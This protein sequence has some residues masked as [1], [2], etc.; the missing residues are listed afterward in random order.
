[1][2][3]PFDP[4]P[5]SGSDPDS[6]T[7]T[8]EQDPHEK[9]EKK[10]LIRAEEIEILGLQEAKR[11]VHELQ[12]HQSKLERENEELRR[13]KTSEVMAEAL[14]RSEVHLRE[15]NSQLQQHCNKLMRRF[16]KCRQIEN[17]LKR[18]N[19]E[20]AAANRQLEIEKRLLSAVMEALPI[21]VAITN[22]SGGIVLQNKALDMMWGERQPEAQ[23]VDEYHLYKAFWADTGEPVAPEEWAAA[24]AVRQGKATLG[25]MLRLRRKDGAEMFVLNSSSPIHDDAGKIVGA[26][27][28][29][30]DVT[31]LKRVQNA[32]F[33]SE[34]HLR[35]FIEHSPVAIAVFDRDMHYLCAS[36]R[37]AQ[38]CAMELS[39]LIGR[40]AYEIH[41]VPE[42][43]KEANRR[44]LA[45]EVIEIDDDRYKRPDGTIRRMRWKTHPWYSLRGDIGGVAV[46]IEDVTERK[47]YE[48]KLRILNKRLEEKVEQQ[49]RELQKTQAR[50]L[51]AEKLS[52]IGK[53]SATIA[54]EL[55]NPLQS[56]M[57]IL[58]GMKSAMLEEEDRT[59]LGLA[60]S[61]NQRMKNLLRNLLD[62]NRPSSGKKVLM[63]MH[64]AIDSVLLLCKTDFK[65]KKIST[66]LN[67]TKQLPP[68]SVIPDQIKQVLFNLLSNA[69]DAMENGGVITI[70]TW[71]EENRIAVAIKDTGAG[72]EP[73]II[74]HIFQP[75]FSTKP[76]MKGT[77]LGLS[78][79]H[80]IIKNH[81]GEI[82]VESQPAEGSTF[83][84]FLPKSNVSAPHSP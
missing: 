55:N 20:L 70:G 66:V 63:D 77:G 40:P 28:A 13:I 69:A 73:Q 61:E 50:Y 37:W 56:V 1:M 2:N 36:H 80:D 79:C 72:I 41:E 65:H 26:V 75:F 60:L 64:E 29:M 18:A 74:D 43:W 9:A 52:S 48:K 83:T 15:E 17:D 10:P 4:E 35:L 11:L 67:Y 42:R 82:R 6:T 71:T 59:L 31:E 30:Q 49:T 22:S 3:P 58:K 7:E 5:D 81:Q 54:H 27:A 57:T 19:Q 39:E 78:V 8:P 51:H 24:I 62:F 53:L 76:G 68:I 16:D 46:F 34:Q 33:E 21:G 12:M 14:Q 38:D 25:Q 32:L 23:S 84:V 45:G 44:G 47:R